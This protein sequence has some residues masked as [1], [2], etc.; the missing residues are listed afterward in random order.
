MSIEI[1]ILTDL[2]DSA[3]NDH[4]NKF[5]GENRTKEEFDWEFCQTPFSP[6]TYIH[7]LD[8]N[9]E[10]VGA[11]SVLF[12]EMINGAGEKILTG[13]P[14][15]VMVDIFSSIKHRKI[16][17]FK[18][19]YE[20]L[21][22]ECIKR[23]V[24]LLW[25]FTYADTSFERLGFRSSFS[26]NNGVFVLKPL[27]SYKYLA[28]LNTENKTA[29]LFKIAILSCLSYVNG[30]RFWFTSF[31]TGYN[32][33]VDDISNHNE[34]VLR[35]L[36]N[37]AE[38]YTLNQDEEYMN[39]RLNSNPNKITYRSISISDKHNVK[40]AEV[41]YSLLGEVAYLDQFI[42][43]KRLKKKLLLRF[44]KR[45]ISIVKQNDISIMRFMGFGINTYNILEMGF[46]KRL[47]FLFTKK[48][49]PFIYKEMP[50]STVD[51]NGK[52]IFISRLFTQGNL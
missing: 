27:K 35:H 39:W 17:I 38:Y 14:E 44:L 40:L 50:G 7:A 52:S 48:G 19:L 8:E 20:A 3:I 31:S 16:D 28:S 25:G 33:I 36:E 4:Y 9:G 13:K 47:G 49:I 45:A 11:I 15:D 23:N 30:F 46:L 29:D 12:L 21:E 26:S 6:A 41:I 43:S 2:S 5:H 10:I 22:E 18:K 24:L 51:L 37:K 34:L 42:Y 32:V 1:K